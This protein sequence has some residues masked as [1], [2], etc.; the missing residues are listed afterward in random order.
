MDKRTTYKLCPDIADTEVLHDSKGRAVDDDY[1]DAAVADALQKARGRGRPSLSRSGESPLLRVRLP[2]D[3]DDAV[4][5]AA[6]EAGTSR[7]DWVR[8]VL[9]DAS[10]KTAS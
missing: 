3:L 9:T 2:R 4:R 6:E 10:R 7:S 8:Q 5:K 1:I